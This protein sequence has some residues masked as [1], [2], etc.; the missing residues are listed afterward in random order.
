MA[1]P[2]EM[3]LSGMSIGSTRWIEA[4]DL[5]MSPDQFHSFVQECKRN[6]GGKGF[7]FVND[8]VESETSKR[9][10]DMMRIHRTG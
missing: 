6:G 5:G 3:L 8:H 4:K 2:L 7:G 1:Y 9:Q 10:Y